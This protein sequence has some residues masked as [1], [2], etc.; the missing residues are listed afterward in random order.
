MTRTQLSTPRPAVVFAA[1]FLL[2]GIVAA[3][4]SSAAGSIYAIPYASRFYSDQAGDESGG[5]LA[6]V[7][8]V[9]LAAL[10][11]L[12]AV[13][14]AVLALL[15][16]RGLNAARVLTLVMISL[17]V[18]LCMATLILTPYQSLD[19]YRRLSLITTW[20]TFVFAIASGLLVALPRAQAYFRPDRRPLQPFTPLTRQ[21]QSSYPPPLTAPPVVP[22]PGA[23][24]TRQEVVSE[25]AEPGRHQT[26]PLPIHPPIAIVTK[27]NKS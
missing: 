26:A 4:I 14:Y 7:G 1:A 12:T 24:Q 19:W 8:L 20:V 23:A 21:P 9:L 27:R 6:V 25:V 11:L 13:I 22:H 2:A 3:Q 10:S 15:T 5:Q 16:A 17:S 18:I